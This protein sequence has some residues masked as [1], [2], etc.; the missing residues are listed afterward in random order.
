MPSVLINDIAQRCVCVARWE[1]QFV[2][3]CLRGLLCGP[4]FREREVGEFIEVGFLSEGDIHCAQQECQ[5]AS[6]LAEIPTQQNIRQTLAL[7]F[8]LLTA[9]RFHVV[10]RDRAIDS[11]LGIRAA[12]EVGTERFYAR[13]FVRHGS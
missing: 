6:P 3:E 12:F 7:R 11:D 13:N 8:Q 1:N 10:P 9:T 5:N 4:A 2:A